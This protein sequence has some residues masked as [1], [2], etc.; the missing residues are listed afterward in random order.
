MNLTRWN[1]IYQNNRYLDE[2]FIKK[3]QNDD[4]LYDKN[5]LELMVEIGEFV[6][7]TKV[8]KYWTIKNPNKDKMLEEYA[9]VITMILSFYGLYNLEIQKL[10]YKI[11]EN[12]ILKIIMEL[13]NK[14][15]KFYKNKDK[16][17]LE[18]IFQYILYIGKL[19]DLKEIEILDAIEKKQKI[20]EERLNS[21][22]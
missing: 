8:F 18:E 4:R 19:L 16:K 7:E 20:I 2:I 14:A 9:D 3:Y 10:D 21:N 17:L 1:K 22:Y 15:Y 12:D 11:D 5:C 6:N 13:Y